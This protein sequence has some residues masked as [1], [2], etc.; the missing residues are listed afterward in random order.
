MIP[1]G[2]CNNPQKEKVSPALPAILESSEKEVEAYFDDIFE[3]FPD[4][5]TTKHVV[6]MTGLCTRT[7][8][9]LSDN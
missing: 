7:I 1:K 3:D 8:Q 4:I 6:S 9:Q 5:L 2:V